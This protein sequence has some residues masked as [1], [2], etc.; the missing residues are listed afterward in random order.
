MFEFSI[1][2][3]RP[4]RNSTSWG[5]VLYISERVLFSLL[6]AGFTGLCARIR[7]YLPF[8]PVPV[9]GQVFAVLLSAVILGREYGALSQAL[10]IGLGILGIPWFVVGPIGPTG[11]YL[12][13]FIT[14]PY[15]LGWLLERRWRV[16]GDIGMLF[17][18][19]AAAGGVVLIYLFGSVQFILFT[20]MGLKKTLFLAV[21]PFIPF[22]LIKA[23]AVTAVA[24]PCIRSLKKKR[25]MSGDNTAAKQT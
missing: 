4:F 1:T 13:G 14:A 7:L 18:F 11:G 20:G 23:A 9:T 3:L 8:T 24:Y 10:Y 17:T 16:R 15:L 19:L 12:V 6:F 22:D 21:L 5:K 25:I 2:K